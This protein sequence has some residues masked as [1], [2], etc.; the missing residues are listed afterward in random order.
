VKEL[1][2]KGASR[3]VK[4]NDGKTAFDLATDPECKEL[5]KG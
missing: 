1:L 2:E 5:L 4:N 3:D